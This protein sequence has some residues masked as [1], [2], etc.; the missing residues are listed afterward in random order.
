MSI[1][2]CNDGDKGE[3]NRAAMKIWF[4]IARSHPVGTCP[5][6]MESYP[7]GGMGKPECSS[8]L[9]VRMSPCG[10]FS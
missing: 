10:L 3:G 8:P 2:N 4:D 5:F 9:I 6:L 7:V 1:K